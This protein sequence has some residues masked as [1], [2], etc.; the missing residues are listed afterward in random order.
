MSEIR[1]LTHT[2][3]GDLIDYAYKAWNSDGLC[4]HSLETRRTMHTLDGDTMGNT[5]T[6]LRSDGIRTN[7]M[8]VQWTHPGD[9][10]LAP[11]AG[12]YS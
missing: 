8:E 4:I 7:G 10:L 9:P 3:P 1:L 2:E 11:K 6:A 5:Y 12:S